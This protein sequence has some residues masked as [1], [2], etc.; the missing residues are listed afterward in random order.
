MGLGCYAVLLGLVLAA[1]LT[2]RDVLP[3]LVIEVP[4][5]AFAV[6]LP[7]VGRDPRVA[8]GPLELSEPGLWAAWGIIAKATAGIV[9]SIVLA[10]TTPPATSSTA[11]SGFVFPRYWCR[12]SPRWSATS[13]W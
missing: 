7:F 4:F 2:A 10:A 3:R 8:V 13:T 12:S 11:S 5:I 6:L 9:V 1:G